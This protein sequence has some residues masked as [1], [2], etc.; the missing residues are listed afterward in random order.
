MSAL[1]RFL[2]AA[3]LLAAVATPTMAEATVPGS[4]RTWE[5]VTPAQPAGGIIGWPFQIDSN[6]DKL[7]YL[8]AGPMPGA[9]AG[10]LI[11]SNLAERGAAGWSNIPLSVPYASDPDAG[12]TP[13]LPLVFT[14]GFGS[15]VW[16]ASVP[17]APGAPPAGTQALYRRTPAEGF[18]LL[19][20]FGSE[21]PTY[22]RISDDGQRVI[23][24]S[25][26]HFL[27]GD[28]GR[29]S[30]ESIYEAAGGQLRL[31]DVD[32]SDQ[33]LSSC[34]ATIGA[35]HA[36]SES[37]QRIF[38]TTSGPAC[39]GPT[40]VYLRE[41]GTKTVEI[42][43]S[44][45][46]RLDCNAPRDVG[47]AGA[48]PSGSAAFLVTSQQLVNADT[49]EAADLYRFDVADGELELL[50]GGGEETAA[51]TGG[52]LATSDDGR[53]VYFY[54]AGRLVAGLGAKE[55]T[56]LYMA[57]ESGL[58]FLASLPET[59]VLSAA[60]G[61][62][63]VLATDQA[64]E[65]TDTDG[66]VDVYRYDAGADRFARVSTGPQGGNGPF[67][68]ELA[69]TRFINLAGMVPMDPH[70]FSDD[71]AH[72]FF[73]TR[74]RLVADD[75]NEW[76]DVYEWTAAG[77]ALVSSGTAAGDVE[78]YGATED[79]RTAMFYTDASLL[80]A[81]QDAGEND[82]YAARIGGGFEEPRSPSECDA[83]CPR[84]PTGPGSGRPALRSLGP[85]ARGRHGRL[86][87][88]R[89]EPAGLARTGEAL[90]LIRV[91]APGPVVAIGRTTVGGEARTVA[92]GSAGA[93]RAGPL[94]VPLSFAGIV[95][96]LLSR[97][98]DVRLRLTIRQGKVQTTRLVRLRAAGGRR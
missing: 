42:S 92:R 39:A 57:D 20:S 46:T 31:V 1:S 33:E 6:G 98:N 94:S 53:R 58:R 73:T 97:G 12:L 47:L 51:V 36:V 37:G 76:S 21:E 85:I 77:V 27:P 28:A 52:V 17:L 83:D 70:P 16:R 8:S 62:S 82:V 89:L 38:F 44:Q 56:N 66:A 23:F 9:A 24:A 3:A 2:A 79:G 87:L 60:D 75:V 7:A 15:S 72:V 26:A 45:C 71:G 69:T 35:P 10:D 84:P 90:A 48:T 68:A 88:R 50:S 5:L 30:G 96:R 18:V 61:G 11:A 54:A 19:A 4:G 95:R 32:D 41:A 55:G 49:D 34:G 86:R 13:V 22:A 59:T 91:P 74:E 65:A 81:D 40:R 78:F 43:A 93:V 64:L 80:P 14:P 25:Y 29:G 67:P 63:A